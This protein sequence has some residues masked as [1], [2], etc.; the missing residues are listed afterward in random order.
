MPGPPVVSFLLSLLNSIILFSLNPIKGNP[1]ILLILTVV[2]FSTLIPEVG[3][4]TV[5][6]G[7]STSKYVTG[8]S[9]SYPLTYAFPGI[10]LYVSRSS[11]T[12]F[13]S[14]VIVPLSNKPLFPE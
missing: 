6:L 3:T 8:F 4:P 11:D 12:S 14:G 9:I 13:P 5:D 1:D 7:F 2:P 10:I